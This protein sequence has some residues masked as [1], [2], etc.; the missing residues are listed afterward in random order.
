MTFP[1][2]FAALRRRWWLIVLCVVLGAAA[3]YG[4]TRIQTKEYQAEATVFVTSRLGSALT[5]QQVKSYANIATTTPV[6]QRV[7]KDLGIGYGYRT[8]RGDISVTVPSETTL[9]DLS[10]STKNAE[11]S[12]NIANSVAYV[13]GKSVEYLQRYSPKGSSTV[14]LTTVEPAD[15]PLSPSSPRPK[16][17]IAIGVLIGLIISIGVALATR[18]RAAA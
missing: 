17:D 5:E 15:K 12:T 8:L 10:V 7:I 18:E 14:S 6:L 3:G 2:F 1:E 11:L 9:I 13:L 4:L 16:V